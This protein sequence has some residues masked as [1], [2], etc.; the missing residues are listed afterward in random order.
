[1]VHQNVLSHC[2]LLFPVCLF[3]L[4]AKLE[5]KC[6]LLQESHKQALL[7]CPDDIMYTTPSDVGIYYDDN[8]GPQQ[9]I[10]NEP[11]TSVF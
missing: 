11:L 10:N 6:N 4:V 1:M 7:A 2:R 9:P 5:E 8:G 3:Q